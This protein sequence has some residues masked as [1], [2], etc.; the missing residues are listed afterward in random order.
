MSMPAVAGGARRA[1]MTDRI[2]V[3][4]GESTPS[5]VARIIPIVKLPPKADAN[6]IPFLKLTVEPAQVTSPIVERI[7]AAEMVTFTTCDIDGQAGGGQL[8][9][10]EGHCG[11]GAGHLSNREAHC[12]R[13]LGHLHDLLHR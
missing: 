1:S 6:T 3:T 10:H 12:G 13:G 7:A 8:H 4:S 11:G 5:G 9:V 2:P